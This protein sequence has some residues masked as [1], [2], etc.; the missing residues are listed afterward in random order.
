MNSNF[1]KPRYDSGG[2]AHLP[3]YIKE[4]FEKKEYK[5]VL[6]FL[7]DGFGWRFYEEYKTHPFFVELAKHGSVRKITSQFPSTTAV[8]VTTWHTDLPVGESGVLEWQYY[9]P[10]LDAIFASLLFSYA[11]TSKRDTA[12]SSGIDPREL[13]PTENIYSALNSLGVDAHIF[14]NQGIVPSTYS[15]IVTEGAKLHGYQTFSEA[16]VNLRILL[17]EAKSPSYIGFYFGDVDGIMH[18]YGPTAPQTR[19]EIETTLDALLNQFLLPLKEDLPGETLFLFTADHGH[20]EV[21]PKTTIFINRDPKFAGVEKFLKRNKAGELLVPSGSPRDFF[22]YI[23]E[24]LL[25]EAQE[26]FQSRLAGKADVVKTQE[27]I[28]A[29]YFGETISE[30]FLSRVGNLVILSYLHESVWWY[31]KDNFEMNYYGHH[32][33][34]TPEEMEIPLISA[35]F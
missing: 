23:K 19:A 22:L 2:F 3:H 34:L 9:E 16:M 17:K 21:D 35:E 31:E 6:F 24:D 14:Q 25:D 26:F 28:D 11:G 1:V 7:I 4:V 5:K 20:A 29:G 8:H 27:L 12:K 30:T 13:Y 18:K 33:G 32:G 10:K 15:D